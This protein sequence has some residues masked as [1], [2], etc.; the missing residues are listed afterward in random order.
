[1]RSVQT[2]P[3]TTQPRPAHPLHWAATVPDEGRSSPPR[4]RPASEKSTSPGQ[5]PHEG[6]ANR[7]KSSGTN[8]LRLV[9]GPPS[10][11]HGSWRGVT[12]SRG[13]WPSP[14]PLGDTD[15]TPHSWAPGVGR[16]GRQD[17]AAVRVE[18]PLQETSVQARR[19]EPALTPLT[20]RVPVFPLCVGHWSSASGPTSARPRSLRLLPSSG[21]HIPTV[22]EGPE[23]E[24]LDPS[25]GQTTGEQEPEKLCSRNL[26]TTRQ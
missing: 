5:R 25:V 12:G 14:G 24:A 23:S 22:P 1:M 2:L 6:Y 19:T 4:A 8:R 16:E 9:P 3:D 15:G 18:V 7:E 11:D 10:Q 26:N 21:S 17:W 20:R 13:V